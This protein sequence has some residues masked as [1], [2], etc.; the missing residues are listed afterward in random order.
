VGY[1][2]G[3]RAERFADYAQW[4]AAQKAASGPRASGAPRGPSQ[5]TPSREKGKGLSFREKQEWEKMEAL[6][7]AAEQRLSAGEQAL[8]DPSIASDAATLRARC[9]EVDAARGEVEK[10]FARWAE[11]EAKAGGPPK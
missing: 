1:D 2:D 4:E 7:L 6:I 10:L 5:K 9:E 11:L 3:G 8:G